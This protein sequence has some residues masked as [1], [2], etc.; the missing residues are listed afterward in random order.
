M[1]DSNILLK[2]GTNDI[3]RKLEGQDL[4]PLLYTGI[5]FVIFNTLGNTPSCN[6]NL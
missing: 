6:I 4:S 3:G 5:I 2:I 1:P